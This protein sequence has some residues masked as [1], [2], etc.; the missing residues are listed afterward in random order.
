MVGVFILIC[1]FILITED[2][3]V[4]E[5]IVDKIKVIMNLFSY[6]EKNISFSGTSSVT[7][8]FNQ[9]WGAGGGP[10]NFNAV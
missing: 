1:V 7:S 6:H 10:L 8:N 4:E 3:C 9:Q 5:E 2:K